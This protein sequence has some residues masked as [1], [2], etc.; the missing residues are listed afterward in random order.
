MC[1][2]VLVG[3]EEPLEMTY[4]SRQWNVSVRLTGSEFQVDRQ[5]LD[6]CT[7]R[8]WYVGGP[9]RLDELTEDAS[10]P[11]HETQVGRVTSSTHGPCCADTW[12]PGHTLWTS[13]DRP[14]PPEELALPE[15]TQPLIIL[16]GV[17]YNFCHSIEDTLQLVGRFLRY[18]DEQTS[19][20]VD[21]AGDERIRWENVWCGAVVGAKK[22]TLHWPWRHAYQVI[23]RH[24]QDS[25]DTDGIR[26]DDVGTSKCQRLTIDLVSDMLSHTAHPHQF[27]S[28]L[29]LHRLAVIHCSMTEMQY[30]TLST[31]DCESSDWQ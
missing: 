31:A 15:S 4:K 2:S 27:L 13:L 5:M 7:L 18:T 9:A 22:S 11:E 19:A 28:M 24:Q 25:K 14:C 16:A 21:P 6:H 12:K 29:S 26:N 20:T 17:G 1:W 8:D 30:C 3:R 23:V 10:T